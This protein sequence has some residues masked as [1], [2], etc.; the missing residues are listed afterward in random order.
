MA[1]ADPDLS[2]D[3]LHARF[4][5]AL[6]RANLRAFLRRNGDDLGRRDRAKTQ[7]VL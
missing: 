7:L 2:I 1:Q 3:A 4:E 5:S 6:S